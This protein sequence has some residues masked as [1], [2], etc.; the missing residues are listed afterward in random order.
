[1]ELRIGEKTGRLAHPFP[2]SGRAYVAGLAAISAGKGVFDGD[3]DRHACSSHAC[4][5]V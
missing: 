1:M 2:G 4:S 5:R 3:G